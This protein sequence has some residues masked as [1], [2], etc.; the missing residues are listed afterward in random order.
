M[1]RAATYVPLLWEYDPTTHVSG[2]LRP[3]A[4][5]SCRFCFQHKRERERERERG[6]DTDTHGQTHT[7][8]DRKRASVCID[9][10]PKQKQH[11]KRQAKANLCM[12][13]ESALKQAFGSGVTHNQFLQLLKPSKAAEAE[14]EMCERVHM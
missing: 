3:H 13:G 12:S 11:G 2:A 1:Q 14:R 7:F 9:C 6:T 10:M 8:T 5:F 4:P